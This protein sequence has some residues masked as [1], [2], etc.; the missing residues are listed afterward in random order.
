M[1]NSISTSSVGIYFFPGFYNFSYKKLI[2][3]FVQG[4]NKCS[5]DEFKLPFDV[6]NR[7]EIPDSGTIEI[8]ALHLF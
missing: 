3:K 8:F 5:D 2:F 6:S 1:K 7:G 4:F